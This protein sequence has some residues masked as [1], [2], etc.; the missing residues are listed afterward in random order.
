MDSAHVLNTDIIND[1]TNII[2]EIIETI[3]CDDCEKQLQNNPFHKVIFFC[4]DDYNKWLQDNPNRDVSNSPDRM[5]DYFDKEEERECHNS[6]E[7]NYQN[8]HEND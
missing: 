1:I 5:D 7:C 2:V 8:D 3:I 6:Y 4:D